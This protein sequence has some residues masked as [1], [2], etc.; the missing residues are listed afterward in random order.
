MKNQLLGSVLLKAI[1]SQFSALASVYKPCCSA[2]L[3]LTSSFSSKGS[4]GLGK[5]IFSHTDRAQDTYKLLQ[6]RAVK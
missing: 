5:N 1:S 6:P 2:C 4:R 3:L